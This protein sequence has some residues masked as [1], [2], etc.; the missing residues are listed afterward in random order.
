MAETDIKSE[1]IEHE[2]KEQVKLKT[3]DPGLDGG[4]WLGGYQ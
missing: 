1:S 3:A 4:F 2:N